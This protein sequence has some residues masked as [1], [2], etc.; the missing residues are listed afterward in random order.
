MGGWTKW[1]VFLAV[2]TFMASVYVGWHW[3]RQ[4]HAVDVECICSC[5]GDT[6]QLEVRPKGMESKHGDDDSR[7]PEAR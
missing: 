2:F 7:G 5:D 3:Y 6:A 4:T 1:G